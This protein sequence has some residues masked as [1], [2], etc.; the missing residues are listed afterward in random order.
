[1]YM[2]DLDAA[3]GVHTHD[4][5]IVRI[6]CFSA[7]RF[8]STIKYM[9]TQTGQTGCNPVP[10]PPAYRTHLRIAIQTRRNTAARHPPCCRLTHPLPLPLLPPSP[11]PLPPRLSRRSSTA[12]PRG[13]RPAQAAPS[14]PPPSALGLAP[15]LHHSPCLPAAPPA[16]RSW[17][18]VLAVLL[19][20]VAPK[21][22]ACAQTVEGAVR[23]TAAHSRRLLPVKWR[24]LLR[25]SLGG[26]QRKLLAVAAAVRV[27]KWPER[28]AGARAAAERQAPVA[29]TR[30]QRT[31]AAGGWSYSTRAIS[32]SSGDKRSKRPQ[33][34]RET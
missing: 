26:R 20:A 12:S 2:F 16:L 31:T 33:G 19:R 6:S 22:P 13:T 10:L 17:S 29:L 18:T 23:P 28:A 8:P 9:T 24:R 30:C 25:S 27:V 4:H 7:F 21:R 3:A 15:P 32:F 34:V 1:M 11:P 5:A 14:P